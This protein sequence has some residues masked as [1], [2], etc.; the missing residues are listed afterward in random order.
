MEL[1]L[2]DVKMKNIE[3]DVWDDVYIDDEINYSLN[4]IISFNKFNN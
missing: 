3:L 1:E 4:I 2:T